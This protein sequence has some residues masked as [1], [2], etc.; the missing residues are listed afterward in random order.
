MLGIRACLL[1]G[2]RQIAVS[3]MIEF[4]GPLITRRS[5]QNNNQQ[6]RWG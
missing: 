1:A 5:A 3:A 2:K 4:F 6:C